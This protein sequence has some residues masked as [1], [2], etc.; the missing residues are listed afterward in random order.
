VTDYNFP[1][2]ISYYIKCLK[3]RGVN[4]KIG[5][6]VRSSIKNIEPGFKSPK[7]NKLLTVGLTEKP[8]P[9]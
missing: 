4:I 6:G 9:A 7:S 8:N 2:V 3:K 5:C 1:S